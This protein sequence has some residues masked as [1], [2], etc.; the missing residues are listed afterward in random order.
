[1]KNYNI[2]FAI[3]P[4]VSLFLFCMKIYSHVGGAIGNTPLIRLKRIEESFGLK[5]NIYAK[6]ERNN[7]SGSIKDR[8]AFAIIEEGER[9]GLLKKDTT[10]V[11]ATSGN[12]GISLSMIASYKGYETHIYMPEN[13]SKERRLMMEAYGAKVFLTPKEEGMDGAVKKANADPSLH[14]FYAHQFENMANPIAHEQ[15]GKEIWEALEGNVD[16]FLAGIGTGGTISGVA[17]VLKE[18]KPSIKIIGV[19]PASSPLL[20]QGKAGNHKIQGLGANFVPKTLNLSLVDKIYDVLDEEAIKGTKLLAKKEGILA[21]ISSGAAL[22][23]AIK[24]IKETNF[25]GNIAIILPDNGERYLSL[26]GLYE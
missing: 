13:S 7:P 19:E 21:G 15:T 6:L 14:K 10:I 4:L 23:G 1:M 8:A 5:A 22:S 9:L 3:F 2:L 26:G 18:K 11:E 25:C 17:K 20:T 24:F 12:M 16:A